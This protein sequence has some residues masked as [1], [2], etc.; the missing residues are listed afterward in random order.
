LLPIEKGVLKWE[1]VLADIQQIQI[2]TAMALTMLLRQSRL[3]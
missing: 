1:L 3:I 2:R